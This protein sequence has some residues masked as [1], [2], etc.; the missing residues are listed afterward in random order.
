[1]LGLDQHVHVRS[2]QADV[3]D[4]KPLAQRRVTDA[5]RIALYIARRRRLPTA[6]TI[7]ITTCSAWYDLNTGRA[8]C[9]SP[10]R[11]P[12][13]FRPAPRRLP[14]CRNSCCWMCHLHFDFVAMHSFIITVLLVVNRF[15]GANC[16]A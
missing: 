11:A 10:A 4:P 6:G 13:G 12:F 16:S 7:R 1:V 8:W 15:G 3:H 2:L 5:A 9:R 14:P